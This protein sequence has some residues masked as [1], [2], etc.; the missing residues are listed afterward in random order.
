MFINIS[1]I[2]RDSKREE[3]PPNCSAGSATSRPR[4]GR[5]PADP[6]ATKKVTSRPTDITDISSAR[7]TCAA[8]SLSSTSSS[9]PSSRSTS[10]SDPLAALRFEAWKCMKGHALSAF[11]APRRAGSHYAAAPRHPGTYCVAPND[12]THARTRQIS[13][14][15]TMYRTHRSTQ[16]GKPL[17]PSPGVGATIN[18][19]RPSTSLLLAYH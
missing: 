8:M 9:S 11:S 17:R 3:N 10:T 6:A 16:Q 7:S 12:R 4:R 15:D 14:F 19:L 1:G 2:E 13:R 5:S 18:T